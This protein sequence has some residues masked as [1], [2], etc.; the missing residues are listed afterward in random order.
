MGISQNIGSAF[1]GMFEMK[2]C[3]GMFWN[4]DFG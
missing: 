4:P 2:Y 1:W 3:A